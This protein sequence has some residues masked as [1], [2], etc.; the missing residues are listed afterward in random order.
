MSSIVSRAMSRI[1][2]GRPPPHLQQRQ[3]FG[4]TSD[5]RYNMHMISHGISHMICLYADSKPYNKLSNKLSNKPY[6]KP[7]NIHTF[8]KPRNMPICTLRMIS[9]IIRI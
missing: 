2:L 3:A 1:I 6:G 8:N 9:H 4:V 5:S 7:D